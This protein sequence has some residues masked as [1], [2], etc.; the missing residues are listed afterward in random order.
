MTTLIVSEKPAATRILSRHLPADI[1]PSDTYVAHMLLTG[2]A[3]MQFARGRPLSDYPLIS[4]P[5][6]VLDANSNYEARP[7]LAYMGDQQNSAADTIAVACIPDVQCIVYAADCDHTGIWAFRSALALWYGQEAAAKPYEAWLFAGLDARSIDAAM[8]AGNTTDD[9]AGLYDYARTKRY[10]EY[11][12]TN[13]AHA[14]LS[15][16][17]QAPSK[18]GLQ[19]LYFL[20][21]QSIASESALIHAMHRWNGT[22]KYPPGEMGSPASRIAVLDRLQKMG[23]VSIAKDQGIALSPGG[24]AFLSGLHPDCEDLDLPQRLVRW[25][26]AGL[27]AS[28]PGIDK[29]IRTVFGKQLR[30]ASK[31]LRT[32]A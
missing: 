24:Q 20:R 26:Q 32:V 14:V 8:R 4:Q 2:P 23:L 6:F 19:L 10:F 3:R 21:G 1:N 9:L 28:K 27:D 5:H 12:W 7:L 18:F 17:G 22:G 15:T 11:Q 16:N 29:Y 13:N 31:G 30:F 25:C